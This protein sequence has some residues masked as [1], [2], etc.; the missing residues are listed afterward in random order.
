MNIMIEIAK[1]ITDEK[2]NSDQTEIQIGGRNG[3]FAYAN[4]ASRYS[5]HPS[6]FTE[7]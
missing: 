4:T 1:T 3:S 2:T 7:S 5:T 6:I